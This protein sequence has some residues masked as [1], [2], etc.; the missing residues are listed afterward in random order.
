MHDTT[1]PT[2]LVQPEQTQLASL[3]RLLMDFANVRNVEVP[4]KYWEPLRDLRDVLE[5]LLSQAEGARGA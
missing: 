5:L 1:K 4:E 3:D 2:E